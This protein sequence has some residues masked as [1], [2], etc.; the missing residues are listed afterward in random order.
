MAFKL[1]FVPDQQ[2]YSF[3]EFA[4][5]IRSELVGGAS[6]YRRD[7]LDADIVVECQFTLDQVK[8]QYF[9][10]FYNYNQFGVDPFLIDLILE[11][12]TLREYTA[13][14]QPGSF[15]LNNVIGGARYV[16]KVNLE[17]TRNITGL[18][19]DT[20][21]S[22]FVG[23]FVPDTYATGIRHVK[24]LP[25]Q[26][27]YETTQNN[28]V[29]GTTI[30]KVP[31]V[32]GILEKQHTE[33]RTKMQFDCTADEYDYMRA[34]YNLSVYRGEGLFINM[35]H[36]DNQVRTHYGHVIPGTFKLSSIKGGL[37]TIRWEMDILPIQGNVDNVALLQTWEPRPFTTPVYPGDMNLDTPW[38][39]E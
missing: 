20:V 37:F 9:R 13:R 24:I 35:I 15:R 28:S 5:V 12:S 38:V 33:L 2:G 11:T 7:V 29:I 34:I 8:Q 10:A 16:T 25:A 17:V 22:N 3:S 1:A 27:A 32:N 14:F 26:A 18:N 31:K 19:F 6:R 23:D 39:D 4:N 30:S 36:E 21:V